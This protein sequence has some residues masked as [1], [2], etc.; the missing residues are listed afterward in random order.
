M[1]SSG[2]GLHIIA[3]GTFRGVPWCNERDGGHIDLTE[4]LGM[5]SPRQA[6]TRVRDVESASIPWRAGC[7]INSSRRC[8]VYGR[9]CHTRPAPIGLAYGRYRSAADLAW[10]GRMG[11][12]DAS[13]L[14]LG[15]LASSRS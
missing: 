4:L 15:H 8:F 3:S 10:V 14:F 13:D 2:A 5:R 9:L 1:G 6:A 11:P 12:I 7:F